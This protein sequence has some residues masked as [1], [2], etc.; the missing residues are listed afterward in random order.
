MPAALTYVGVDL[1]EP[2]AEVQHGGDGAD[3][4]ADDLSLADG[5][6]TR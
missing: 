6:R 1:G 3:G 4:K 2:G 5:L